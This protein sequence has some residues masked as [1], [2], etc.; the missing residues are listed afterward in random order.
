MHIVRGKKTAVNSEA[1]VCFREYNSKA[2]R[3]TALVMDEIYTKG[4]KEAAAKPEAV[5]K[6]KAKAR[7]KSKHK[8]MTASRGGAVTG[9]DLFCGCGGLTMV[10]FYF[11]SVY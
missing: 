7:P 1:F 4:S 9:F 6:V 11:S 5:C 8:A 10:H 2:Q 3:F